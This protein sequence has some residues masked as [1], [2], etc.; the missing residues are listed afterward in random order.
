MNVELTRFRVI[1]GAEERAAEWMEF[2]RKNPIGFE[3]TLEPE[4]MY[5]ETIF[6]ETVGGVTYLYWYSVQ[7]EN[8]STLADSGHWLDKKH[9]EF[10]KEC[11][12]PDYTPVDLIEEVTAIP[13]RVRVSMTERASLRRLRASDAKDVL[14]AFQ[15]NPDMARQGDVTTIDQAREYVERLVTPPHEAWAVTENDRVVGLVCVSV[16]EDNRN[17]WFWYWMADEAR[18]RGWT[19]RAAATVA[20]WA[21][22]ERGLE[23]LELG[24]RVNNPASGAVARHAGFVKEGTERGKFLIGGERIDVETYGRLTGDPAPRF[25]PIAIAD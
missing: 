22:T 9:I 3:E 20:H 12:D 6:R 1:E 18:G 10:W 25:E 2:L 21:L 7:G 15:S 11:I 23:R 19:S 14:V 8:A 4:H 24:H 16:D 13:Q 5:V 17:G